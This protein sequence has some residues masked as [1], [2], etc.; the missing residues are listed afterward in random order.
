LDAAV[1]DSDSIV[2][3]IAMSRPFNQWKQTGASVFG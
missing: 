3:G 2:V 1:V